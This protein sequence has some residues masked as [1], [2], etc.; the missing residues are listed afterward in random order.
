[1]TGATGETIGGTDATTGPIIG[2]IELTTA[3]SGAIG[4]RSIVTISGTTGT[5][6][7]TITITGTTTIG[8]TIITFTI[9]TI[10]TSTT[11]AWPHGPL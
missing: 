2:Q 6:T 1:M 9:R 4:A 8:G 7:G 10:P 3:T 5:T 11:G